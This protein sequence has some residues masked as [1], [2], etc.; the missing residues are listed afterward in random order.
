MRYSGLR[1]IKKL[2]FGYE[3]IARALG[4]SPASARVSA[5]RYVKQGQLVRIK[6]NLYVTDER[7]RALARDERF[8]LANIVQV[9]SYISLM[10]AL[11]YYEVTTQ[12]QRDYVESIAV[13]RTREFNVERFIFN[14]IKIQKDLYFGFERRNNFFIA[15]PEKALMDALY[16][17]SFKRYN[18]DLTSIDFR[19]MNMNKIKS[20]AGKYPLR[21]QKM[22]KILK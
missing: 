8:M 16:L 4:V 22:L 7:W 21:T 5:N 13:K 15:T 17:L 20:L 3:D 11:E 9:P 19:K 14:Y 1:A 2:Y 18:F 6:R 12:I 10:T